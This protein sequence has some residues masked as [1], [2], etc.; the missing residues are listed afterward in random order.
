MIGEV[1]GMRRGE[2]RGGGEEVKGEG[3]V[4]ELCEVFGSCSRFF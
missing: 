3:G 2:R 4:N 1:G